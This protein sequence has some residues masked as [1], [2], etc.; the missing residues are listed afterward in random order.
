MVPRNGPTKRYCCT[1]HKGFFTRHMSLS[2]YN[3]NSVLLLQG[4]FWRE[5]IEQRENEPCHARNDGD[6]GET[7]KHE[8]SDKD[9][10][11]R[12]AVHNVVSR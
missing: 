2:N 3:A 5:V 1:R 10:D 9:S 6:Y 12:V 4:M 11:C 8:S 7:R